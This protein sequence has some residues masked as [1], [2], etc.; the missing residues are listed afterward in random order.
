M[1]NGVGPSNFKLRTWNFPVWYPSPV[2]RSGQVAAAVGAAGILAMILVVPLAWRVALAAWGPRAA[3]AVP[4][5]LPILEA[6]RPREPFV[7]DPIDDLRSLDPGIVTIGDSMAGR[8]DPDLLTTLAEMPIGPILENATGSAYWYL[9]LK[10]YVVASG[11]RPRLVVIFFRDTNLTDVLFRLDGP[12][13][14]TLDH[15]A[16][17]RE[18]ELNA[19]VAARTR[20]PWRAVYQWT[21]AIYGVSRARAWIEPRIAR[22]PAAV[23]AGNR[24]DALLEHVNGAFTLDKLRTM[25]QADLAAV[26]TQ[27]ANFPAHVRAS[28]LPLMIDLAKQ[29]GL[30]LCFVRVLRRPVDGQPPEEGPEL[31]QYVR[32]LRAYLADAG[33][34][35]LDDRDDPALAALPYADGDHV[36]RDARAPYTTR[37]WAK[38]RDAVR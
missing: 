10:N 1:N 4:S 29:H 3:D 19:V 16:R 25:A 36:S 31:Q 26:D 5:Y 33:M 14:P 22:W 34:I 30:R 15:V 7:A 24:A 38:V 35:Y 28:V 37:F 23:V 21:E 11:I 27:E 20:G 18:P 6:E 32:D 17:D 12:Y 2:P 9:V 8:I 13:R